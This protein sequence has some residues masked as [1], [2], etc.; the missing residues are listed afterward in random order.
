MVQYCHYSPQKQE[1]AM[2]SYEPLCWCWVPTPGPLQ[3]QPSIV[4][5]W[6]ICLIP[7]YNLLKISP[8]HVFL[9]LTKPF[10]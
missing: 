1:D 8:P 10:V 5:G 3:E 6:A 2:D 9:C 4:N 7:A